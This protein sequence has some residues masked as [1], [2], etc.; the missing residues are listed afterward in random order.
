VRTL[1][2]L[3]HAAIDRVE[4]VGVDHGDLVDDDGVNGPEQL[5]Q[6][7]S[8]F[9]LVI[10][11]HTDRQPKQRMD[12]LAADIEGRD[13]G[14]RANND[15]LRRVPR[16]VIQQRRF[17]CA[18]TT[19]DKDVIAR[20]LDS[21]EYRL[22]LGGQGHLGHWPRLPAD[23][24][25]VTENRTVR[26]LTISWMIGFALLVG[27]FF[28]AVAILNSTVYSAHGFVSSYL[29][30]LNRHDATTARG[31]PECVRRAA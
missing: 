30:A 6:F 15:L 7:A 10:G 1:P 5:A 29:D 2:G 26:R 31:F 17:A 23:A 3:A 16:Q 11:N 4:Q 28:G 25:R 20:R 21:V 14:R 9:D 12:G 24:R 19:G 8:L 27:A 18:R 13:A 22:L